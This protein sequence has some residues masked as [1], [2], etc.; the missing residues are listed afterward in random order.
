MGALA[1]IEGWTGLA[2]RLLRQR[3]GVSAVE[4]ALVAPVL[5]FASLAVVDIG[6]AAVERLE[7]DHV[8]RAGAEI[9]IVEQDDAAALAVLKTTARETFAVEGDPGVKAA[10]DPVSVHVS[11]VCSCDQATGAAVD[12]NTL[13]AGPKPPFVFYDLDAAKDVR[14]LLLPAFAI[15]RSVRVQIR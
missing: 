12:C 8:L 3:E 7:V 2:R 11:I 13:C 15:D 4:F 6:L 10:D 9:A 14:G 1:I 5:V